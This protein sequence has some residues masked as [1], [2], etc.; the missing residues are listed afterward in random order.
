MS[1]RSMFL[2]AIGLLATTNAQ[3]ASLANS[4]TAACDYV[5]GAPVNTT[6]GTVWGHRAPNATSVSEYLGI[7]FAQPPVGPLRFAPPVRYTSQ[8]AFNA[9]KAVCCQ[10][11][12]CGERYLTLLGQYLRPDYHRCAHLLA[13]ERIRYTFGPGRRGPNTV[14]RLSDYQ[15]MV[16]TSSWYA[17]E[18]RDGLDLWRW[19]Q[20]R[21]YQHFSIRRA[22][23]GG[24]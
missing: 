21:W 14:R 24:D 15:C 22:V 7:P 6:S 12:R 4:P 20:S 10:L 13:A 17:E 16:E 9:A 18:A 8:K 23:L 5:V 11:L 19:L 2:V 1:V 3:L